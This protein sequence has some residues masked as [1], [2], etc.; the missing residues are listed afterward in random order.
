MA[1]NYFLD[2]VVDLIEILK[3]ENGCPWDRKQTPVSLGRY[4]VEEAHESYE[5]IN[6]GDEDNIR[7]E[8]GDLLFQLCF[9]IFLYQEKGSFSFEDVV[10]SSV[11][12]MKFRHPHVFSDE[13]AK[14]SEE[15]EKIWKN[16]K[17]LERKNQ[18]KSV[19][20]SVP[21]GL[22]ALMKALKISEEAVKC[23]FEWDDVN[24]VFEKISEETEELKETF[25]KN[26]SFEEKQMEFGD[27]LFTVVNAGRFI[28][29][30]S[31]AALLKACEKFE[32]RFRWMEEEA[33]SMEKD[34][35][36]VERHSL[37]ELWDMAKKICT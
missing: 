24:G 11:L 17:A 9:I 12:K 6:L 36:S 10:K 29:I 33:F 14:T 7:E 4:L 32:K 5:A 19:M 2:P 35:K 22:C 3:S 1:N 18:F 31:E 27:L 16:V 20:D 30:E 8:L 23:G 21:S 15:V 26:F 25:E 28:G 34:I 13:K 37:E